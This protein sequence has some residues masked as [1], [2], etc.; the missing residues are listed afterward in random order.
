ME[1]PVKWAEFKR[2]NDKSDR[3]I[4]FVSIS[5]SVFIYLECPPLK[6]GKLHKHLDSARSKNKVCEA[7]LGQDH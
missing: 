2:E 1:K 3:C 7:L 4:R 5:V 6:V